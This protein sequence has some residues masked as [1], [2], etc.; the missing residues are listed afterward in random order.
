MRKV[1]IYNP[2]TVTLYCANP[3]CFGYKMKVV[4]DRNDVDATCPGCGKH[5]YTDN[6]STHARTSPVL[7]GVAVPLGHLVLPR[8]VRKKPKPTTKEHSLTDYVPS[9][10]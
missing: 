2:H 4:I 7:S 1:R 9:Q 3:S 10:P 8:A 5:T 6:L